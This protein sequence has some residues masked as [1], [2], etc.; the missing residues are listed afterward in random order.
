[1]VS[2]KRL[3]ESALVITRWRWAALLCAAALLSGCTD[4]TSSA[5]TVIS[6]TADDLA[7]PVSTPR[8]SN[9]RIVA[10]A[11]GS[12]EIVYSLGFAQSLAGRD[13]ASTFP[14][15]DDVPIVT[16]AHSVSAEKVLAQRPSIVLIDARTG[17]REALS[18][19]AAAGVRIETIPEAW[20]LKDMS[21]RIRSIG[22]VLDADEAAEELI[23]D[24]ETEVTPLAENRTR[25]AFLYL[26][27]TASI[28]LLGGRGSGADALLDAVGA[29]DVGSERG[30][31]AFTPLTSEALIA[32]KPEILLVMR[33][34]LESVG[35]VDGLVALP[36]VAQTPAGI[37]R[38]VIAVDDEV[39]LAFGPRTPALLKALADAINR[40]AP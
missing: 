22:A 5:S 38:R 24:T 28:Y 3:T 1:M 19:I 15:A 30:L 39:L 25:V 36:G 4:S 8:E 11:N 9:D 29:V 13:I 34:G 12:A 2:A 32:A 10:L 27:G 31:A 37:N 35:G 14:G 40:L 7:L 26:R 18:Q 17:P 16:S 23:Q 33:K 20:T 6:I 21:A